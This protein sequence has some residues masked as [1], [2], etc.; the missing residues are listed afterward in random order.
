MA[1]SI[2][3]W[4]VV[5]SLMELISY[6]VLRPFAPGGDTFHFNHGLALSLWPL[7]IVGTLLVILALTLLFTR[8]MPL[9]CDVIALGTA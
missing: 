1:L 9:F 7:F 3:Y 4:S 6:I 8:V 2:L 5:I